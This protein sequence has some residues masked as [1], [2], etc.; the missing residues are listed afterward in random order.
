MSEL[1]II[2]VALLG[3]GLGYLVA[4]DDEAIAR[5]HHRMPAATCGLPGYVLVMVD[6][7]W[8]LKC[9]PSVALIEPE[10]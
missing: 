5:E 8:S 7:D 1:S 9:A 2:V 4:Q 10:R 3:L 6:D